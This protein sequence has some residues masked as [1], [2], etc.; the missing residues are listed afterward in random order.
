M[1]ES[2]AVAATVAAGHTALSLAVL[3][4]YDA[5]YDA[6]IR[7]GLAENPRRVATAGAPARGRIKQT[8]TRNLLE[9]LNIH[10]DAVLRFMRDFRVPFTNNQ[11]ESD[12]R[13][14][15]VRQKI[16]GTFRSVQGAEIFCR[17]RS[18]IS[19]LKKQGLPVFEYIQKAFQ[20]AAFIPQAAP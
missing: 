7:Q 13:M 5:T 18:Y 20:G 4:D 17:I 1:A 16:S 12:V 11:A 19:T 2:E 15:K 10:R 8:K 14:A 9:R 6:I 3:A